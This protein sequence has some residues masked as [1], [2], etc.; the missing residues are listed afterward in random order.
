[1]AG[2]GWVGLQG[3]LIA[4]RSHFGWASLKVK[5]MFPVQRVTKMYF[6]CLKSYFWAMFL[7]GNIRKN[8]CVCVCVFFLGGGVRI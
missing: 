1:M 8:V 6:L 7:T 2:R 3:G 5:T 4:C